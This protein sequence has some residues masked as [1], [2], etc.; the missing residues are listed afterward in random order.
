MTGHENLDTDTRRTEQQQ[1]AIRISDLS[2]QLAGLGDGKQW[3]TCGTITMRQ[4]RRAIT[5][6][7]Y[8][9]LREHQSLPDQMAVDR[10]QI[11]TDKIAQG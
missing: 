3:E 8:L 10:A 11:I 1:D 7:A 4:L 5:A 9:V 2:M 6:A